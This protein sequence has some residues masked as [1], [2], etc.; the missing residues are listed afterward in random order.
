MLLLLI[1]TLFIIL[2]LYFIFNLYLCDNSLKLQLA[3]NKDELKSCL[4]NKSP[5]LINIPKNIDKNI[6]NGLD[7]TYKNENH[8]KNLN[9]NKL[10]NF[11]ISLL[12]S[13]LLCNIKYSLTYFK[14]KQIISFNKC[15][16]N[17]HIIS[18]IIGDEYYIYLLHPKYK[19]Y[20]DT[21]KLKYSDK[22]LIKPSDILIIPFG[23]EYLQDI[24][25]NTS[26]YHIDIDNYFT[27]IH[28]YILNNI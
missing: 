21:D 11:D 24:N 25:S 13:N 20:N 22:I 17:Y 12:N 5:V 19:N 14:E 23:W 16:N 6:F 10:I 28:N 1:V 26:L 2:N 18:N 9:L 8:F 4:F 7:D 27:I 15:K 3:K